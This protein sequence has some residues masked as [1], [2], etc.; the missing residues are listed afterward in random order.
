M[1]LKILFFPFALI[2]TLVIILAYIKPTVASILVAR[3]EISTLRGNLDQVKSR[4]GN[5]KSVIASFQNE[6]N[7]GG[8]MERYFPDALDQD[9][10]IDS[11]NYLSRQSGVSLT[12]ISLSMNSNTA[13]VSDPNVPTSASAIFAA[14]SAANTDDQTLLAPEFPSP[15]RYSAHVSVV[16]SY[17]GIQNFLESVYK[18]DRESEIQS[19]SIKK[20]EKENSN[21]KNAAASSSD[22]EDILIGEMTIGFRYYRSPMNVKNAYLLD[23]FGKSMMDFSGLEMIQ[24]KANLP[25]IE[26]STNGRENPFL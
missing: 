6:E 25:E 20:K 15:M 2:M 5:I 19:F 22:N 21:D 10:V 13:A 8:I 26:K 3:T 17:A 12:A 9:R 24:K 23:V 16:G 4:A 14:G 18:M 1:S 7:A 11:F